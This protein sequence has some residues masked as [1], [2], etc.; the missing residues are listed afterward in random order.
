MGRD[1][2]DGV[3]PARHL[4]AGRIVAGAECR[5]LFDGALRT[6]AS[7]AVWHDYQT[8]NGDRLTLSFAKAAAAHGAVLANYVEATGPLKTG[9]RLAGVSARDNLTGQAFEIRARI[10]VNAGGPWA[11]TLFDRT[12]A[13]HGVAALEGDEPGHVASGA[14]RRRSSEPR[15]RAARWC[16]CHGRDERSSA[17]ANHRTLRQPDDQDARRDEVEAFL[18]EINE[19][20][21]A[22]GLKA[23][24]VTLVHRGI[25]PAA[26]ANGRVSL[27]GQSRIIDHGLDGHAGRA[28]LDHRREVHDGAG[29]RRADGRSHPPKAQPS[30]HTM[31]DRRH[32]ASGSRHGRSRSARSD[33]ATPFVR[34]WLRRC[35]TS[36]SGAPDWEPQARR[37]MS[38]VERR[39]GPDAERAGLVGSAQI[40]RTRQR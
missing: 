8:I 37:Q 19:T 25:V 14:T 39:S 20:F 12:G 33:R 36:S 4:P 13:P 6:V 23:D 16:C 2:N 18:V 40:D 9:E 17:P 10:L 11:A 27:L 28:H 26:V 35:P 22:L 3:D 32:D 30:S 24:D 7:A 38:V 31:P 15:A 5:E 1:R 21:P 29:C 34:K